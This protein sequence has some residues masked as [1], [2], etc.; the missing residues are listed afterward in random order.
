ME[1]EILYQWLL[2]IHAKWVGIWSVLLLMEGISLSKNWR[3]AVMCTVVVLSSHLEVLRM[4]GWTLHMRSFNF[5]HRLG[6]KTG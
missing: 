6:A 4:Q 1:L 2:K 5:H 3:V